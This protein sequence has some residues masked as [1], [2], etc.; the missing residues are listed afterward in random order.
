MKIKQIA[1]GEYNVKTKSGEQI[2]R[3]AIYALDED[4][5]VWKAIL[6]K[7]TNKLIW[8]KLEDLN[9]DVLRY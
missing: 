3:H 9:F 7:N 6:N 2:L 5:I 1:T 4:G 8:V